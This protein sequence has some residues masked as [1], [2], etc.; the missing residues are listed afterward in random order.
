MKGIIDKINGD[1]IT[2]ELIGGNIIDIK[3]TDNNLCLKEGLCVNLEN[4]KILSIDYELTK[5][6]LDNNISKL[7]KLKNR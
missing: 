7:N 4:S 2:I 6:K 3:N 5:T 1:I